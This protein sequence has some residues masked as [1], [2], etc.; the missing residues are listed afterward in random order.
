M[1]DKATKR[2]RRVDG[3]RRRQIHAKIQAWV[4]RICQG[5]MKDAHAAIK[6]EEGYKPDVNE[7]ID[8]V[9]AKDM[10]HFMQVMAEPWQKYWEGLTPRR[11]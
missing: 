8:G 7:T 11:R 6:K 9:P 3:T 4:D 1:P 2:V 5:N 10:V